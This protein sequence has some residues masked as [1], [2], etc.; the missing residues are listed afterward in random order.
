MTPAVSVV[1]PAYNRASTIRPAIESVLRQS[2]S[3][4]EVIIV[5]DGST[6]ETADVAEAMD[7]PRLRVLRQPHNSGAAAARNAGVAAARGALVAFQDS[8][9]EW[10]PLKLEKQLALLRRL[11][12]PVAVYCGMLVVVGLGEDPGR[13]GRRGQLDYLPT[14]TLSGVDGDI[15]PQLLRRSFVSTQTLI[16]PRETLRAIGGFDETLP[17]LEDWDC[18]LRLAQRGP[19]GLVDEPLVLQRFSP[20]SITRLARRLTEA[21]ERIV[22]KHAALMAAEP[23]CLSHHHRAV[24]GGWRRAGD[25]ARANAAIR[26][27]LAAAPFLPG[28]WAGLI[29]TLAAE[30]G[31]R[32]AMEPE[33]RS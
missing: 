29:M 25:F 2:I 28:N 27:A 30:A 26:R 19:I 15:L 1:I 21:R 7:D 24:A 13:G 4:I 17:A 11:D 9:D 18:A 3:D 20:N 33:G 6:D 12:R 31:R 5:D 8:D 32:G 10:L 22:E 23:G 16:A 14:L